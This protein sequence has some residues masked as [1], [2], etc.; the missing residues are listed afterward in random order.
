MEQIAAADLWKPV[1]AARVCRYV[2]RNLIGRD[3]LPDALDLEGHLRYSSLLS[4]GP[5]RR[6]AKDCAIKALERMTVAL[7]ARFFNTTTGRHRVG[8]PETQQPRDDKDETHARI[9]PQPTPK[10]PHKR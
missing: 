5:Q 8:P 3:A 7:H 6:A 9:R 4:L 10:A 2:N 1:F